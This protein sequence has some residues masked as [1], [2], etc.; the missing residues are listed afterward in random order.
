MA[1][2]DV[3][4]AP[5]DARVE[6]VASG[7]V[8]E[9]AVDV[10]REA[11]FPTESV[12][13]LRG[14][15]LL[16]VAVPVDLGGEGASLATVSSAVRVLSRSCAATA[17]IYAMH[18]IQVWCLLRHGRSPQL[19]ALLG[20]VASEQLLLAS[21]TTEVGIG[22]DVRSSTCA[23]ESTD[24]GFALVK[25][26]PVISY[27]AHA[28]AV[29][30]TARRSADSPPSDQVLV[31]CLPPGL[32]LEPVGEWD[33]LGFRG[34]D[35]RGFVLR[36]SGPAAHILSDPYGD[37]SSQTML[38]VSHIVWASVWLGLA[39]SAAGKAHRYVRAAAR[40]SAG[41][42]PPSA[43]RLAELA[44]TLQEYRGLLRG[45]LDLYSEH[46]DDAETLGSLSF[47]VAMNS[48]KL[49]ASTLV[50]E[51][52]AKAL[53]ICGMAGYRQDSPYSLGRELRDAYGAALMVNNDRVLGN[54][55][56]LLL[57]SKEI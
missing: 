48:L 2:L 34:T 33:T 21:A 56:R 14:E 32:E 19:T 44:A 10:D 27:G 6:S 5:I 47:A 53:T 3:P 22:G 35:S 41:T 52:V 16:S 31:A 26:A 25:Q 42:V 13:A 45:A 40:K 23:V 43:N 18:Q 9:T 38:P 36:A 8:A 7:A 11:R 4:T 51:L 39:E 29:L 24:G 57:A 12:A 37:I 49:S 50:V 46:M 17:M 20:R 54:S 1:A 30:A 55:A 28:D 15:R